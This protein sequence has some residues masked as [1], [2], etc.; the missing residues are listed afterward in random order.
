[1]KGVFKELICKYELP[2]NLYEN[3]GGYCGNYVLKY[4]VMILKILINMIKKYVSQVLMNDIYKI[5]MMCTWIIIKHAYKILN[6]AYNY[7]GS[8]CDIEAK[9]ERA[10]NAIAAEQEFHEDEQQAV[11]ASNNGRQKLGSEWM[12][13]VN[14]GFA[15]RRSFRLKGIYD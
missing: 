8:K 6:S 14:T 10:N 11:N 15:K 7:L 5:I 3:N 13:D 2:R 9:A 1:M 4:I 12:W